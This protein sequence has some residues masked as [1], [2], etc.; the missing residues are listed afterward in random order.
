MKKTYPSWRREYI[1]NWQSKRRAEGYCCC[2]LKRKYPPGFKVCGICRRSKNRRRRLARK[3]GLCTWCGWRK[4]IIGKRWCRRCKARHA[5]SYRANTEKFRVQGR[6]RWKRIRKEVFD[7]YGRF[8][9]CCGLTDDRFLTLDHVNGD[10]KAH[11]L[12]VGLGSS[13]YAWA[14]KNGCPENLEPYCWNCNLGKKIYGTCPHQSQFT[15]PAK[16]HR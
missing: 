3:R 7:K 16:S 13:M 5:E 11:R 12:A 9:R 15:P 1:K 2:C 8:C 4:V 14:L 10:G 6:N